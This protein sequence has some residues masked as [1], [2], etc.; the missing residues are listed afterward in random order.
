MH[1]FV[2][3]RD[4]RVGDTFVLELDFICEALDSCC[5]DAAS[6]GTVMFRGCV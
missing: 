2:G 3:I 1:N 5:F 4:G 6:M